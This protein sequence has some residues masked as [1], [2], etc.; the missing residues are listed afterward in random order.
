MDAK[1]EKVRKVCFKTYDQ[2]QALLVPVKVESYVPE[3]HLGRIVNEVVERIAIEDL[4]AFYPGGGRSAYHP[5]MMIKVWLYGYCTGVY[6]SRRLAKALRENLV[7]IWLSG[8]QQPNFKTLSEFR[9]SKMQGLVDGV[10]ETLLKILVERGYVDLGD[11]YVDGSKWEANANRHKVVWRSNTERYKGQVLER[12]KGFLEEIKALQREEDDRYGEGD[13]LEVGQGQTVEV[14]MTSRYVRESIVAI[15]ALASAEGDKARAAKMCG[16]AKKLE[17]E[18]EKLE[19]YEGQEEVL[20]NRNSYSRTDEDAT[21][22]RLKDGLLRPAYNVQHSTN[23]QYIVNFTVTQRHSDSVTFIGHMEKWGERLGG[24]EGEQ[25]RSVTADAGYGSE[26]N[27]A[28]LEG[29]GM[30]AYVKYPLWH[31]EH[32]GEL[33]QKKFAKE[34]WAYDAHKRCYTCPAGRTLWYQETLQDKTENG[35]AREVEVFECESCQ[36]CPLREQCIKSD[37]P[38]ANRT[39]RHSIKGEEYKQTAKA[40]LDSEAGKEH[41]S[42]RSIEVESAFGDIKYNA[43]HDRFLLRG[44]EKVYVEYGLLAMAH[45]IRKMYCLESGCWRDYYAQRAS[46]K[47]EKMLKRA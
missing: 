8:N 34:N 1:V 5:K 23:N 18:R 38:D 33:Q 45:N 14:V 40:L 2:D 22:M 47:G 44:K 13:L 31:Q 32:T 24:M 6:T 19:K 9:G 36:G 37:N 28:Y 27:Y 15:Q 20:G 30:E 7:M 42:A 3:G 16:V 46:K 4:M 35:Y 10:F 26:E 12:I 29:R 39:V 41:R 43:K 25:T 11:L 17:K 21:A